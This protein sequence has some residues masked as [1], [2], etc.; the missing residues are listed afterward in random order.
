ML[1]DAVTWH[2]YN[3]GQHLMSLPLLIFCIVCV[4]PRISGTTVFTDSV[5]PALSLCDQGQPDLLTGRSQC[6]C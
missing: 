2:M 1:G 4:R 5:F 6:T 3:F